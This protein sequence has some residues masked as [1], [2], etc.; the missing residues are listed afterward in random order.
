MTRQ[1]EHQH[2][3]GGPG[4]GHRR[5]CV[6]LLPPRGRNTAQDKVLL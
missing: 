3:R 4:P 2:Q 6:D 1:S 5:G